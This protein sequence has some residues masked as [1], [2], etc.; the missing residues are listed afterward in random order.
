[1]K[2]IRIITLNL[3]ISTNNKKLEIRDQKA[4]KE[5]RKK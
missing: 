1:M 4:F 2:D 5:F 3:K